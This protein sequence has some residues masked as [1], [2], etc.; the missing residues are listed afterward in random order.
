[1]KRSILYGV[2][3]AIIYFAFI[4]LGLPD[5][6][7][8]IAWPYMRAEFSK[9]LAAAGILTILGTIFTATSSILSGH[10]LNR[11]GTGR[12][13]AVSC[14][15]TA[16]GLLGYSIAPSF[17]WL[18][19]CIPLL[20]FGAGAIDCGL[21][22]YIA[23]NYSSRHM[24]WLHC[25]W[26]IG[27]T[28]GPA[29]MTALIAGGSGWRSGYRTISIIQFS[30]S[31]VL[32]L[33]IGLWDR[34]KGQRRNAEE[35]NDQVKDAETE[36]LTPEA[37]ERRRNRAIRLQIGIYAIYTSCEFLVGL[38][39]FSLL[40]KERGIDAVTA[41]TWVSLYYAALTAARFVNGFI[42]D[43]LGNRFMIK[44][45]LVVALVGAGL[46]AFRFFVPGAPAY[47]ELVGLILLGAGFGPIYP[48]MTHETARRFR[49]DTAQK[50]MG[51]QTGAA[52]LGGA[53]FPALVGLI[54]GKTSLEILP[55]T[56]GLFVAATLA[57][58]IA[59]DRATAKGRV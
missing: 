25:C 36:T 57:M 50:V 22:F 1:M 5:T 52:N 14:L 17:L 7:L 4:S 37:V 58:T 27:A 34:V 59:L 40:T 41:G 53:G 12:V 18:L 11:F 42:V 30:L 48:C 23:A 24:N 33:S 29:I 3:L 21:N 54:A 44:T 32:L 31:L 38:W 35:E 51:Y 13:T 6:V 47:I 45:G 55:F 9:P 10:V 16:T 8:G 26:G 49:E 43:R 46:F 56:I 15:M 39:A 28:F 2:L 20:G 19:P